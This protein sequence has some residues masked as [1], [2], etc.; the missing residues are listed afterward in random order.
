MALSKH[1]CFTFFALYWERKKQIPF[2]SL[3][4]PTVK[5]RVSQSCLT[6]RPHRPYRPLNSPGQK[7][8]IKCASQ[9]E[10]TNLI[11][12]DLRDVVGSIADQYN[13]VNIVVKLII[14]I[15][16]FPL[17]RKVMFTLQSSKCV[18]ALCLKNN[19][20]ALIKKYFIAK[21]C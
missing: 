10:D 14:K 1:I 9:L 8:T 17:H 21:K 20:Q 13:K 7:C 2:S 6:L 12:A 5:V 11:Q 18:I 4:L 15:F 3:I 16:G 19:V